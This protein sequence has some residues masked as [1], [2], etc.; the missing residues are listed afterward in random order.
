[1]V[2]LHALLCLMKKSVDLKKHGMKLDNFLFGPTWQEQI[3]THSSVV[4]GKL[5]VFSD[6]Q[7]NRKAKII[8]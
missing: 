4:K 1:M 8:E 6:Y 7:I 2:S 5:L 3:T